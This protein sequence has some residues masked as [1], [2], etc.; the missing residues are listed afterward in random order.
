[1]HS[2]L[3]TTIGNAGRIYRSN[4]LPVGRHSSLW[5][6]RGQLEMVP[7]PEWIPLRDSNRR[8][9][10]KERLALCFMLIRGVSSLLC[11]Q[12]TSPSLS[13]RPTALWLPA[14]T[15]C[16][17]SY[18]PSS[19]LLFLTA[20]RYSISLNLLLESEQDAFFLPKQFEAFQMAGLPLFE[21]PTALLEK[22]INQVYN[23]VLFFF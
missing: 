5:Y 19:L 7:W 10:K 21:L 23:F 13:P 11:Q 6:L 12:Q 4:F 20:H 14:S 22:I 16:L 15:D 9:Q 8:L 17:N 18:A 3:P 1:M 2:R